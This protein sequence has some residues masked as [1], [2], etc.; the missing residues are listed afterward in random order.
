MR[1][2][3]TAVRSGVDIAAAMTALLAIAAFAAAPPVA[4]VQE[5]TEIIQGVSVKDPYR[6]FEDVKAP[7]VQAWLKGQGEAARAMLDKIELRD[8]LEKRITELA[9]A[10]GDQIHS[11]MRMPG[12][13]VYY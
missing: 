10:T 2:P 9:T 6:Y 3:K 11:V 7:Q 13:L 12:D 8:R 1:S 5:V 4:P